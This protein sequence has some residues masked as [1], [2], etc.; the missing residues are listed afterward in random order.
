[1]RDFS[2]AS[3][4]KCKI[5]VN[6][7]HTCAAR[8][9][10]VRF[11]CVHPTSFIRPTN[12]TTYLTSNEGQKICALFSENAPLQSYRS[13]SAS[14]ILVVGRLTPRKTRMRS[15]WGQDETN[16]VVAVEAA[17]FSPFGSGVL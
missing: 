15:G 13:Y 14:S 3:F 9:T 6:P 12:D 16:H 11:V 1:M 4:L 8:V 17:I 7:R 10:V 5:L 2:S